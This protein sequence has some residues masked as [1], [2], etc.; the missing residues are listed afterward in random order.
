MSSQ[1]RQNYDAQSEAG[2]NRL[3]NQFLHASYNYLSLGFYFTRDD[4]ALS[5]FSSFFRHLSE[6]KHEQAEKLLTFQN[7]RGGRVVLQ[8]VKKPERDE[9]TNGAAAM[10]A[11]LQLEKNLNKAL[12]DLH[13]VATSHTDPHLC[14]FLETHFLDEEVK[15]IKKLGDHVTNLKRV[16]AKDEG[17]GEY[18]FDRLTLGESSD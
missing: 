8:D 5:K 14:D 10:D 16:R 18:L 3:V 4:V 7:R 6:E 13:Q 15:L 2:V 12:L 1:V 17:L 11:A 9:W